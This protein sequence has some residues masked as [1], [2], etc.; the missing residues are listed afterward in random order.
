MVDP[1]VKATSF[2]ILTRLRNLN[3]LQG[4]AKLNKPT[5]K[6]SD[7]IFTLTPSWIHFP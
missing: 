5:T 7:K 2:S 1:N 4:Q 3:K 6:I